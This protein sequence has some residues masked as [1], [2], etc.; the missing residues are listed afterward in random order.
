MTWSFKPQD[1]VWLL[2]YWS[3]IFLLRSD[4]PV[5]TLSPTPIP[6]DANYPS[7]D[8]Q[9]RPWSFCLM[10]GS[11]C[12]LLV[13]VITETM[14]S[15]GKTQILGAWFTRSRK[16]STA[17]KV[18]QSWCNFDHYVNYLA[19]FTSHSGVCWR[20]RMGMLC[21]CAQVLIGRSPSDNRR[22]F[23]LR[24]HRVRDRIFLKTG[25]SEM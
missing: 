19:V 16:T 21:A 17:T 15:V 20:A 7:P 12:P 2:I 23:H 18:K 10:T 14:A 22:S 6:N 8:A 25:P 24:C 1:R 4:W 5:V 11:C 13:P 3:V 9:E